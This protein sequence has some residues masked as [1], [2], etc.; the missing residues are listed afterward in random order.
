MYLYLSS[1]AFL[2]SLGE[3]SLVYKDIPIFPTTDDKLVVKGGGKLSN[4][5][6]VVVMHGKGPV[7]GEICEGV[8]SGERMDTNNPIGSSSQEIVTRGTEINI[9]YLT[10]WLHQQFKESCI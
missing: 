6:V 10:L 2:W 1:L 9:A 8:R 7:A 3:V 4:S 5:S